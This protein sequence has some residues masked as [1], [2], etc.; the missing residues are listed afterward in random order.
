MSLL[1]TLKYLK[2]WPSFPSDAPS[3]NHL[4]LATLR[5]NYLPELT[6]KLWPHVKKVVPGEDFPNYW[7]A[8]RE[9]SEATIEE[10]LQK[11]ARDQFKWRKR[12][13]GWTPV[14][15]GGLLAAWALGAASVTG[16]GIV[17]GVLGLAA[18]GYGVYWLSQV[19]TPIKRGL[20]G[21][22]A[23]A[24]AGALLATFGMGAAT[25]TG[26]IAGGVGV[27]VAG[28]GAAKLVQYAWKARRIYHHQ[29]KSWPSRRNLNEQAPGYEK[30]YYRAEKGLKALIEDGEALAQYAADKLPIG[31][32]SDLHYRERTPLMQ[33]PQ[34]A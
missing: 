10:A 29:F 32:Q 34:P 20:A 16:M 7:L 14:G 25:F 4:N 33:L 1:S 13:L 22:L 17:T 19:D 21:T 2:D 18:L 11:A 31:R 8:T 5:D 26:L 15:A 24:G 27:G 6:H 12:F 30:V 9:K 28:Y 3:G 23:S